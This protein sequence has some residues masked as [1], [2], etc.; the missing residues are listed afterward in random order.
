MERLR[1]KNK[2]LQSLENDKND[3]ECSESNDE[4]INGIHFEYN[5]EKIMHDFD[6][7][8]DEGLDEGDNGRGVDGA[9]TSEPLNLGFATE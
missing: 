9:S 8:F 5:K 1:E 4:T 7:G 2:G 6:G 3:G